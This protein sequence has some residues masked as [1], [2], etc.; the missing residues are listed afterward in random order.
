MKKPSRHPAVCAAGAE[1]AWACAP[2]ATTPITKKTNPNELPVIRLRTGGFQ[3]RDARVGF[4]ITPVF[5]PCGR[6]L[7]DSV[8]KPD[9]SI[10][11]YLNDDI[12]FEGGGQDA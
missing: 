3:H 12:P 7:R 11:T 10:G 6:Q 9:T 8:A 5:V 2:G 4:V 1:V